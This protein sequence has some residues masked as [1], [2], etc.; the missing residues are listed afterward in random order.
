MKQRDREN[1]P[2]GPFGGLLSDIMGLGKT[3]QALGKC[4]QESS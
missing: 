1:S 3:I 4:T 2:E